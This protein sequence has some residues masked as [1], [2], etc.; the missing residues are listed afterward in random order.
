MK[1]LLAAV[2][3]VTAFGAGA[4]TTYK[5][6]TAATKVEWIGKKVAGDHKGL[7]KVKSGDLTA[8]GDIL[9]GGSVVMDMPSLTN[10]DLTDK[11]W[12]DKLVGHL[13]APDFFDTAKF[14]EAILKIKSSKKTAKGLDV[15]GDLTIKGI[16]KPITFTATD[17]KA[18]ATSLTAKAVV[19]VNRINYGVE[20]NSGKGDKSI[21]A[22]LG[23]KMI[24]DEFTLNVDLSAKK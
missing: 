20:Y 12:N 23:D 10:T 4:Q 6:D 1:M 13:K 19:V 15:M 9:S 11:E 5:V 17:V 3:A 16:T 24:N 18:T 8:T 14:P 2:F 22:S 7:I 21:I